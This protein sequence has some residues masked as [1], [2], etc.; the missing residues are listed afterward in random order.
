M[1][2]TDTFVCPKCGSSHFGSELR[3]TRSGELRSHS[4]QC[5]DEFDVGCHEVVLLTDFLAP[6]GTPNE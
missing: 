6:E 2:S 3:K 4:R 1:K 5:H